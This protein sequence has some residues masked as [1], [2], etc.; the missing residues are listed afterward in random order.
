MI[1]II[2]AMIHDS[3]DGFKK[4][5][6]GLGQVGIVFLFILIFLGLTLGPLILVSLGIVKALELM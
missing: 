2:E 5:G 6:Q 1:D 3:I 4:I